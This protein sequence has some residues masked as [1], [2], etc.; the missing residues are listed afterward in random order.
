V[1]DLTDETVSQ[2]WSFAGRKDVVDFLS[3][4]AVDGIEVKQ[5]C[6]IRLAI[7]VTDD[8]EYGDCDEEPEWVIKNVWLWS[9]WDQRSVLR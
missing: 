9:W 4:A 5:A 6:R 8:D 3:D 2:I 7:A 1:I